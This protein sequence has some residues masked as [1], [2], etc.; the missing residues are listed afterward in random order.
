MKYIIKQKVL[1]YGRKM[2]GL[3][4]YSIWRKPALNK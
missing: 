4:D 3:L 1:K 2:S